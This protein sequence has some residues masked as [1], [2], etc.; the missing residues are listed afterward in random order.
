MTFASRRRSS[1]PDQVA[2]HTYGA[3][4]DTK[5]VTVHD[6]AVDGKAPSTRTPWRSPVTR[7]RSSA[8]ERCIPAGLEVQGVLLRRHGRH[9]RESPENDC[10]GGWTSVFRLRSTA[11]RDHGQADAPVQGR[12]G[13]PGL[14]NVTFLTKDKIL[15]VEDA[16]DTL[17]TR[18][19]ALDSG[20][21]LDVTV[22]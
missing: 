17:H 11:P 15:F 19:N 4:F 5:W 8:R 1:S 21:V 22:D 18:R 7:H 9:E 12:Q 10:S 16:G 20:F 2:L 14:D 6:T 3:S 13:P